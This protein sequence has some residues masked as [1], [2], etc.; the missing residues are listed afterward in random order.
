MSKYF[1]NLLFQNATIDIMERFG[2]YLKLI[3]IGQHT[4]VFTE[5]N[6]SIQGV[7][8]VVNQ[9]NTFAPFVIPVKFKVRVR[10]DQQYHLVTNEIRQFVSRRGNV[11]LQHYQLPFIKYPISKIETQFTRQSSTTGEMLINF[12]CSTGC[13]I[14]IVSTAELQDKKEF[15]AM[16]GGLYSKDRYQYT[17]KDQKN[18]NVYNEGLDTIDVRKRHA[19]TITISGVEY[20]ADDDRETKAIQVENLTNGDKFRYEKELRKKDKLVLSGVF[21]LLNGEH[22]GKDTNHEI[23]RINGGKNNFKIYGAEKFTITFDFHFLYR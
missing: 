19:L 15:W 16:G 13:G 17:F 11:Y 6:Y 10:D 22:A 3:E 5:T 12:T 21:P 1:I 18:F 7:D 2:N 20:A 4:P 8:G 9:G 14:S 23:I